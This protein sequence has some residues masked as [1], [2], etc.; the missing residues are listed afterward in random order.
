M[1]YAVVHG[2]ADDK[3]FPYP[4]PAETTP[5]GGFAIYLRQDNADADRSCRGDNGDLHPEAA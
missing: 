3:A 1:S 4:L 5:S 2:V